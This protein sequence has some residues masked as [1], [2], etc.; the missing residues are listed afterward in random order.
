M[1]TLFGKILGVS[2]ID[3]DASATAVAASPGSVRPGAVIPVAITKKVADQWATYNSAAN[4]FSSAHRSNRI[5]WP[6]SGHHSSLTT[7]T[8][9]LY[10]GLLT[11]G[12]PAAMSIGDEIW[13]EPGVK[14]T[15]Y[16]GPTQDSVPEGLRWL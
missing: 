15:L 1:P 11:D 13:I 9:P 8:F 16:D 7:T 10:R 12:N 4:Q 14:D 6:V 3:V 2:T 5:P